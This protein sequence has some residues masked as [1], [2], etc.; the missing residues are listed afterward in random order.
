MGNSQLTASASLGEYTH[1]DL[2]CELVCEGADAGGMLHL[3]NEITGTQKDTFRRS[4]MLAEPLLLNA[5]KRMLAS[6]S[7]MR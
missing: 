6:I 1:I 5:L 4:S 7:S 3:M 2:G